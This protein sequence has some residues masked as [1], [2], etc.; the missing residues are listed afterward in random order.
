MTTSFPPHPA[1]GKRVRS[2]STGRV[3]LLSGQLSKHSPLPGYGPVTEVYVRPLGG[4]LEWVTSP[5]DIEV[6]SE[7]P[8]DYT[9]CR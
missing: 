5:D 1:E 6:L 2:R 4:G 9:G 3:G 7:G 8:S